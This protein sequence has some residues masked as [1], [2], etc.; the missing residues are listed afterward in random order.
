MSNEFVSSV[1]IGVHS[2]V[3]GSGKTRTCGGP[4]DRMLNLR[5]GG[6]GVGMG[7]GVVGTGGDDMSRTRGTGRIPREKNQVFS[8][9][10]LGAGVNSRRIK[11]NPRGEKR[12]REMGKEGVRRKRSR[13]ES[14]YQQK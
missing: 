12:R 4:F 8:S 10:P 5:A 9:S 1:I 14:V 7:E 11:R 6:A 3:I 13:V 2:E